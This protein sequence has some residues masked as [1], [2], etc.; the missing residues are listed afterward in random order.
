[1]RRPTSSASRSCPVPGSPPLASALGATRPSSVTSSSD[2]RV[3]H[4]GSRE[5]AKRTTGMW[6]SAAAVCNDMTLGVSLATDSSANYVDTIV[7]QAREVADAGV[8]S[9]WFGQRFDYDSPALAAVVGR[10]VPELQVGT[11][12]I[13]IFGR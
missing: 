4:S 10:E 12:A 5:G 13:P 9:V 2:P 6:D 3:P 11:S 7:A 8:Q 1:M